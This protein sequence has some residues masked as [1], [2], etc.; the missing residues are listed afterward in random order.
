[1]SLFSGTYGVDVVSP[2]FVAFNDGLDAHVGTVLFEE[3]AEHLTLE[4]IESEV[5]SRRDRCVADCLPRVGR[6]ELLY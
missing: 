5:K 1:M 6:V 4:H 2:V 3:L